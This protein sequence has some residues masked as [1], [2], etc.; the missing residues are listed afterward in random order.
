MILRR[1]RRDDKA[2]T[3]LEFAI[4]GWLLCMVTFGIIETGILWWLKAGMQVT[5]QETARCGAMG[6]TY[7]VVNNTT[8]NMANFLCPDAATTKNFAVN[9]AVGAVPSNAISNNLSPIWLLSNIVTTAGVTLNGSNG[10][11]VGCNGAPGNYFSVTINHTFD[12]PPPLS[13]YT[14]LSASA[15]YPMP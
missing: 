13:N 11:Q 8:N 1:I 14:A 3:T 10:K 7:V 4:V 2:S 5:A 6:L 15:C 9:Y 12:L